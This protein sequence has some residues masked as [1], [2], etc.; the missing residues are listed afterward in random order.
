MAGGGG[1]NLKI[2]MSARL[3]RRATNESGKQE[4]SPLPAARALLAQKI[5]EVSYLQQVILKVAAHDD[6]SGFH[7]GTVL[8]V[9][10]SA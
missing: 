3:R 7:K 2:Y 9:S 10:L 1:R 4:G 8:E 6:A 5:D